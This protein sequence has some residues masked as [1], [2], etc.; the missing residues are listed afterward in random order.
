[1]LTLTTANISSNITVYVASPRHVLNCISRMCK[2]LKEDETGDERGR[3][4]GGR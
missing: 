1:M 2:Q 4:G 3:V